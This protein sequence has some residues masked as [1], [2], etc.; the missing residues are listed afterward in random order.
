MATCRRIEKPARERLEPE[1]DPRIREVIEAQLAAF[2]RPPAG[3]H[4]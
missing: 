4:D 2:E 1:R 3:G